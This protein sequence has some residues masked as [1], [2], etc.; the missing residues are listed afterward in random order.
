MKINDQHQHILLYDGECSFC[1]ST[2][3]W[4]L[5]RNNKNNIYFATLQG[6][7][8]QM[9]LEEH[10]A[11]KDI[12]SV[13]YYKNGKLYTH[14]SAALKLLGQL[15][16]LWPMLQALILVPLPIRNFFYNW[17]AKRRYRFFGK[18]QSCLLPSPAI[19]RR[20]LD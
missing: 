15:H 12:D 14:S 6:E 3:Q 17:F 20:F 16:G 8:G 1:N 9:L 19:R 11:P 5:K 2:V 10:H 4:I 18:Q 13:V 7:F